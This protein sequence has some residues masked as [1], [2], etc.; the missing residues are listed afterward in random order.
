[1]VQG[2]AADADVELGRVR[3]E[4]RL[5]NSE[6]EEVL[7]VRRALLNARELW[8]PIVLQLHRFMV[9]VSRVS[10]NHDGRGGSAPD[11]LV[12]DQGSRKKQRRIEERGNEDL[13][14][15]PGP[16]GFLNG[17]WVQVQGGC[18]SGAWPY[19]V[20]LLCK[21]SSFLGSLRWPAGAADMGHFGVS[22]LEILVLFGQ[23]V[24]HRLLG[25]HVTRP[26]V[27]A[28]RPISI[29]SVPVS[30]GIEIRKR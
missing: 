5:E 28:S 20:S 6:A 11:P 26:H 17:P 4:D 10:V 3:S 9:A 13:A 22:Y 14:M 8:Y 24:G 21:F 23:W 1:M 12:W 19:G 16:P 2:H 7:D 29:S 30:E 18:I 25:E 15:L 27:R